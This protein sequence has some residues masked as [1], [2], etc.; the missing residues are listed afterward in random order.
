MVDDDAATSH[1][2]LACGHAWDGQEPW[3]EMAVVLKA[4]IEELDGPRPGVSTGHYCRHCRPMVE[5]E[6]LAS[7][8]EGWAWLREMN[9]P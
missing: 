1:P 8:E 3:E 9:A 5:G 7:L 4:V 2:I 6:R